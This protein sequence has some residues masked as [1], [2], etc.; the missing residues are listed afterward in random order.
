M[1]FGYS[2]KDPIFELYLGQKRV[3]AAPQE[4]TQQ[5]KNVVFFVS[6]HDGNKKL[7]DVHKIGFEPKNSTGSILRLFVS[8]LCPFS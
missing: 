7:E 1:V 8:E 5:H 4:L 6:G 2:V 3:V